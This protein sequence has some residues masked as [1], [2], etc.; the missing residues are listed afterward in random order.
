MSF[1]WFSL[2]LLTLYLLI[3]TLGTGR[4]RWPAASMKGTGA[5]N[6]TR[7]ATGNARG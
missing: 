2:L 1:H 4:V 7:V 6:K 5:G 3:E